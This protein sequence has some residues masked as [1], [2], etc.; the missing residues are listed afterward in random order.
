MQPKNV[1]RKLTVR[2][3][4]EIADGGCGRWR[5]ALPPFTKVRGKDGVPGQ[6]RSRPT[7]RISRVET[8]CPRVLLVDDAVGDAGHEF[9]SVAPQQLPDAGPKL[10]QEVDARIAANR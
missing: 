1:S 3:G 2:V 5:L 7:D 8:G 6:R 10:V 9:R 4:G